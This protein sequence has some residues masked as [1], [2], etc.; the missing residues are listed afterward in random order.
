MTTQEISD[1]DRLL[2]GVER[3]HTSP[4]V[5]QKV[6][7]LTSDPYFEVPEIVDCLEKDPALAASI[8]RLINSSHFGLSNKVSSIQFAVTYLGRHSLRLAVLSFGLVDGLMRAAPATLFDDYW[9]RALTMALASR[10]CFE[11]DGGQQD[12]A[13][14]AGLFADLGVLVFAQTDPKGYTSAY[15]RHDHHGQLVRIE[16]EMFGFDH[17]A[18]SARLLARWAFPPELTEAV[19]NHQC[20]SAEGGRLGLAVFAASLLA[21]VLW[22]PERPHMAQLQRVLQNHFQRDVDGLISL[23]LDCKSAFAECAA[24]FQVNVPAGDVDAQSLRREAQRQFEL[25]AIDVSLE[26]D[27]LEA[28]VEDH[29]E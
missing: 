26:L 15:L 27:T 1:I 13:F 5:A 17:A 7:S 16:R 11:Q 10:L 23:A 9:R 2:D 25:A 19:A 28:I 12:V 24:L 22:V 14:S 6:L 20:E 4:A 18:V 8:L 21:E 3:L 29:V